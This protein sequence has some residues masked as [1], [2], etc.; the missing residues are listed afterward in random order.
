MDI[1]NGEVASIHD[2]VDGTQHTVYTVQ[3]ASDESSQQ[4]FESDT[5]S[6]VDIDIQ[7]VYD[8]SREEEAEAGSSVQGEFENQEVNQPMSQASNIQQVMSSQAVSFAVGGSGSPQLLRTADTLAPKA[9][10]SV[11][12]LK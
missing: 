5:D 11:R 4:T 10:L 9:S 8:E 6:N 1:V 7:I 12:L 3:G 2:K